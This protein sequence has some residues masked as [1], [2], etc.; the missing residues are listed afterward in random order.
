MPTLLLLAEKSKAHDIRRV[1]A[2][3]ERLMPNLTAAILPGAHH[4]SIPATNP[5][6]LNQVLIDFLT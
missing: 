5:G 2:R 3:A 6:A 4:H 1:R